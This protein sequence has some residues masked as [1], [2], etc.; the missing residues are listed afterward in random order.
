MQWNLVDSENINL[1][2]RFDRAFLQLD[3]GDFR[4]IAGKQVIPIG[5]G[6]I[7]NAVSQIQ[8]YPL[9]FI[10]PEFPKTED[11]ATL[12][13]TGPFQIESRF[14]RRNPG[15]IQ[16][17]FH[18]RFKGTTSGLD[19][20]LTSGVSDNKKFFGGESAFNLGD[21][22]M[23]FELV[24]YFSGKRHFAQGLLGFDYV[25]SPTWST[26]FELFYNGFGEVPQNLFTGL[27]HRSAPFQG[28]WYAGNSTLWE[29]HPLLKAHLVSVFNLKDPSALLHLFFNYS[30]SDSLDLLAGQFLGIGKG[31]SE[32]G[33]QLSLAP[34][35]SLGQSDISYAALRWYF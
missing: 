35:F 19:W 16:D 12:I 6:Q 13:W 11:A 3:L 25:F 14:L 20:G 2:N 1:I 32:F 28:T 5:V 7:F 27:F 26:K 30:L 21:A 33:G 9:I 18:L 4:L 8:R 15:Q 17:N 31:H 24:S 22:L 10:D 23:R 34:G 29:I